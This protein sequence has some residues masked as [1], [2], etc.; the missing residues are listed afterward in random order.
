VEKAGFVST[1]SQPGVLI[2]MTFIVQVGD[3]FM[4]VGEEKT[5]SMK[6]M[7][8]QYQAWYDLRYKSSIASAV[9]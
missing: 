4:Y 8:F 7:N 6:A 5:Q 2:N 3:I 9:V 1:Y